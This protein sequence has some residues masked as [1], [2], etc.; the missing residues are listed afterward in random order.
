RIESWRRRAC[1]HRG[2]AGRGRCAR[3]RR[4]RTTKEP[5]ASK[6]PRT[7]CANEAPR[8]ISRR[9]I[10]MSE[11]V[12]AATQDGV[13]IVQIDNPPVNALSTGVPEALLSTIAAAARDPTVRALVIM[14][15]IGRAHV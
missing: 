4:S 5:A 3:I 13:A 1:R 11:L 2:R 10:H 12:T 6:T 7:S 9:H 15:E 14:G 8:V